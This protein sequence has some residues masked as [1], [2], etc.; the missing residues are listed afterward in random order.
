MLLTILVYIF[1][2]NECVIIILLSAN[3]SS[4]LPH[5]RAPSMPPS[6][7]DRERDRERDGYYSDRN[8]LIRERERERERDRGYLSDHNSR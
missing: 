8:E 1:F 3:K 7:R 4:T 2:K 5:Q 6:T